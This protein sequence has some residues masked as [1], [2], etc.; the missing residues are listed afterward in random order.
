[1]LRKNFVVAAVA[2]T[3]VAGCASQGVQQLKDENA[4]SVSAKITKG[5]S[6]KDDVRATFGDPTE[7]SFTDSGNELWRYKYSHS[8]SKAINFV[9]VVSL[10][11]SGADVDKKELV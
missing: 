2:V 10:F 3:L 7:T 6:T 8:T 5:K 4:S 11:T 9:P 1:M